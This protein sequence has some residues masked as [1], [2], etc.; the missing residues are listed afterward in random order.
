MEIKITVPGEPYPQARPRTMVMYTGRK[1]FHKRLKRIVDEAKAHIYDSDKSSD[2]KKLVVYHAM[3]SKPEKLLEGE[4]E[5]EV[6]IYKKTLKSFSK[7]KTAL[8]ESG[9]LR[10]ITKP[11][12]DNYAKG[13]LDALTG[14]IWKDDGQIVDLIVRKFYS[15]KPR[16]EVT[17]RT[18]GKCQVELF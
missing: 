12:A 3:Q 9:Q 15:S 8:A 18:S 4:L 5:V 11:D 14:I 16:I 10:P 6:L 13:P 7:K 2:Y 1:I 17:V